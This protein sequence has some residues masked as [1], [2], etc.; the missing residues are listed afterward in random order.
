MT[1]MPL[2]TPNDPWIFPLF[3]K[4]YFD[5]SSVNWQINGFLEVLY[6]I[7]FLPHLIAIQR[8]FPAVP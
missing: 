1:A 5:P 2:S 6:D 3:A 8:P 7:C 4:N